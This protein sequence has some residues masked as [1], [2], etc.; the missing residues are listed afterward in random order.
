MAVSKVYL[1]GGPCDGKSVSADE[2]VG[3]AV[4][5][6]ACGGGYYTVNSSGR[7]R[8]GEVVFEY[9][10]KKQPGP[11]DASGVKAARAHGGWSDVRK[12]VNRNMPR[13]LSRSQRHTRAAL[14]ALHRAHRVRI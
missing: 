6:I 1:K 2:I 9:A 12:S 10:G 14:Q 13:S 3:G 4:A 11:P 7:R 5:Y 8:N